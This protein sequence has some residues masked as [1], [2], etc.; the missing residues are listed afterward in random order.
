VTLC[1]PLLYGLH[2]APLERGRRNPRK[3]YG[4]LPCAR[5][6]QCCDIRPVERVS[7]V[8]FGTVRPSPP[9][10]CHPGHCNAVPGAVGA[11]DDEKSPCPLLCS[12][13]LSS[14]VPSSQ[15][16][17]GDQTGNSHTA[18]LEAA[19][20]QVQDSPRC[21]TGARFVR[22]TINSTKLCAMPP[23]VA[24]ELCGTIVNCLPLAY[25]RRR[26]SP[27]RGGGGGGG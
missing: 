23:Y 27:G 2:V 6:G 21:P 15:R 1:H 14:S 25:K 5:S 10:C 20:R 17:D 24:L 22:M 18:T 9:L 7:S 12:S 16:M 11:Q 26:R 19:P 3:S 8:T 13:S 4:R